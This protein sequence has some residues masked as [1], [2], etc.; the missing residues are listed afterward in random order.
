MNISASITSLK[1]LH[2]MLRSLMPNVRRVCIGI[3]GMLG[4]GKTCL[5]GKLYPLL[6]AKVISLDDY[7]DKQRGTY[8]PHIRC[9]EVRTTVEAAISPIL[10]EGTCLRAVSERCGITIHIHVYVRRLSANSLIWHEDDICLGETPVDELK[11]KEREL[12]ALTGC[13]DV[14]D[15]QREELIDYHALWK[16][17]Q[18]ADVIFDVIAE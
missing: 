2:S 17:V 10:I 5:V 4:A 11:Q 8:V 15:E 12:R 18:H 9:Q 1:E 6:G 13:E 16:P 14:V 7:V 3:D